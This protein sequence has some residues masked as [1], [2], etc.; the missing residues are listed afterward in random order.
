MAPVS[1]YG[2][3]GCAV[4]RVHVATK[5]PIITFGS[6]GMELGDNGQLLRTT[7]CQKIWYMS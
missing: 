5:F 1:D 6:L 2:R 7:H 4:A 3:I